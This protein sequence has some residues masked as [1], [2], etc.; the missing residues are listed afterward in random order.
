[1][2]HVAREDPADEFVRNDFRRRAQSVFLQEHLQ[3]LVE[4]RLLVVHGLRIF[5][6]APD[7]FVF[8]RLV[9]AQVD[10]D[11]VAGEHIQHLR[12]IQFADA[13]PGV[14]DEV[15]VS[16]D[17][18]SLLDKLFHVAHGADLGLLVQPLAR[19]ELLHVEPPQVLVADLAEKAGHRRQVVNGDVAG[20]VDGIAAQQ[21]A[22]E[23]DLHGLALDVVED[24]FGQV[25]G[26]D[27]VIARI[28]EPLGLGQ[29]VG[30]RGL[31]HS[32]H[33]EKGDRLARPC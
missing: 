15:L 33:A 4:K 26:T 3:L 6:G 17:L 21:I 31:A 25:L 16:V 29:L 13:S 8:H 7:H 9:G 10:D 14:V 2:R 20:D 5:D 23:V 19:L 30:E 27:P 32:R 24:R 18:V 1:M 22:Q 28:M 12:V 11:G